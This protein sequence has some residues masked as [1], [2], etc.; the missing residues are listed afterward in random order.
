MR[1]QCQC[2][3]V[4]PSLLL[5]FID[6][7]I[8]LSLCLPYLC[9]LLRA[10]QCNLGFGLILI[11]LDS[12]VIILRTRGFTD[13]NVLSFWPIT[14]IYSYLL[15]LSTDVWINLLIDQVLSNYYFCSDFFKSVFLLNTASL[16]WARCV[17]YQVWVEAEL[18]PNMSFFFFCVPPEIVRNRTVANVSSDMKSRDNCS[19]ITK[20]NHWKHP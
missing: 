14:R 10:W 19:R 8:L 13:A 9:H 16:T 4:F 11:L 15:L 6:K 20:N 1:L 3:A 12:K 17:I 18:W 2:S 7:H 5:C